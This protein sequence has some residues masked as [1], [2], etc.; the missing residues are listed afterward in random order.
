[1]RKMRRVR[2]PEVPPV[3]SRGGAGRQGTVHIGVSFMAYGSYHLCLGEISS[4]WHHFRAGKEGGWGGADLLGSRA[5][6]NICGSSNVHASGD[7]LQRQKSPSDWW[8][9]GKWM[10]VNAHEDSG[11]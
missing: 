4:S 11:M 8:H 2:R 3:G 5:Q 9:K 10:G 6:E 7:K 1:M